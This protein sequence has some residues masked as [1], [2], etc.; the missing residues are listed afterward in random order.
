MDANVFDNE[1]EYALKAINRYIKAKKT[2]G[3][4]YDKYVV[5]TNRISIEN[6]LFSLIT[7]CKQSLEVYTVQNE[8]KDIAFADELLSG[9]L[10]NVKELDFDIYK[11][12]C[13]VF[14]IDTDLYDSTWMECLEKYRNCRNKESNFL[15]VGEVIP[16]LPCIPEG[17]HSLA[18]REYSFFIEKCLQGKDR[19]IIDLERKCREVVKVNENVVVL[20]FDN[21]YS[22]QGFR[23][24]SFDLDKLVKDALINH[25]RIIIRND[26]FK[27][28]CS[29]ISAPDAAVCLLGAV[30]YAKRGHVY[31]VT[32]ESR[33]IGGIKSELHNL[34]LS[35]TSLEMGVIDYTESDKQYRALNSTKFFHQTSIKKYI[36]RSFRESFYLSCINTCDIEY[37]VNR[38]LGTYQGKLQRLKDEELEM[39]EEVKRICQKHDIQYF[40]TAGSLIGAVRNQKSIPWDDDLD[41]GMLREDFE[42]FREVAP[43]ELDEKYRYSS[44]ITDPDV[45]YYFDKI[46]LKDTYFSTVYSSNFELN[47]GIF[48]DFIIYDQTANTKFFQRI[49]SFSLRLMDYLLRFKWLNRIPKKP[50]KVRIAAILFHLPLKIVSF[51]FL[52]KMYDFVAKFYFDEKHQKYLLD[53]GTKKK[54]GP[55]PRSYLT[56]VKWIVFDG[57]EVPIPVHYDEFLSFFQGS[58]FKELPPISMRK[59]THKFGRLDLG[60]YVFNNNPKETFREVNIH[61]ELFEEELES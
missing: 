29:F 56:E 25:E 50:K 31:N 28:I 8:N 46:R 13:F 2:A 45:H 3:Y 35:R 38:Y 42:K 21:I 60:K 44:W 20:R 17:I 9:E 23:F 39:L 18:E 14:L 6:V 51:K 15:L 34:F 33:S 27:E 52:H 48:V 5:V 10:R 4:N 26:D 16:A 24:K 37:D 43:G 32:K 55:F 58:N 40:L 11:N 12:T 19:F 36:S 41:I 7:K 1:I 47:D 49:H 61:G 53:G 57:V 59:V 30:R 54:L 22:S